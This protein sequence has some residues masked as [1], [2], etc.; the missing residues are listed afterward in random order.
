MK[1][2]LD[3]AIAYF[4]QGS[5]LAGVVEHG[6]VKPCATPARAQSAGWKIRDKVARTRGRDRKPAGIFYADIANYSRLT[7]QDEEGTHRL[8]VEAIRIMMSNVADN[9]GRI[10]HLGGDAILAEFR[11]ADSA[12]HCAINVQLAARQWNANRAVDRRVLFRIGVNIGDVISEGGDVY[13]NAVNL[14][15]RLE[16]LA[17]SGGICISESVRQ[18][19]DGQ[20][21]YRF[22]DMGNR[23][24]NNLH[25][26]ARVFWIE[27]DQQ[28]VVDPAFTTAV[29]ISAMS[30]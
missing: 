8:L 23:D 10:V 12:L 4:N 15:A 3:N 1:W 26:S 9:H 30:S 5:D 20:P 11:D 7:E 13:S 29:K 21:G 14:A 28:E 16:K 24:D 17:S 6:N 27:V 25:Q 18:E 19:L 2:S 22:V